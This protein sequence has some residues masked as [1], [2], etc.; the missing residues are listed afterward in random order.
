MV[1]IKFRLKSNTIDE[2]KSKRFNLLKNSLR[3]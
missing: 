3:I 2:D 1:N